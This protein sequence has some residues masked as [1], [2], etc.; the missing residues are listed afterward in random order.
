LRVKSSF[1][2]RTPIWSGTCKRPMTRRFVTAED[3]RR[4]N[5]GE[6][7]VDANTVVTPQAAQAARAAG[8]AIRTASG[9]YVDPEPDRG[10]DAARASKHH[11][12]EPEGG[13]NGETG[14]VITAVGRNRPGV[15]GELTHALGELNVSVDNISQRMVDDYFHL[16]LVVSLPAE[17][18]F[19]SLKNSME[20]LGGPDDYV[21]R[22]M[23]ERVFRFMHRI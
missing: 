23:H 8:V 4:A 9:P 13:T 1:R 20:C 7:I 19:E 17:N 6:M 10:P 2:A 5:G 15:L 18:T 22:V 16:A 14:V 12:P 21:V 11:L 3:I